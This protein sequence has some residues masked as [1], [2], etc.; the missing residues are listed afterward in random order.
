MAENCKS[1]VCIITMSPT[2]EDERTFKEAKLLTENCKN[3]IVLGPKRVELQDKEQKEGIEII[4]IPF[5]SKSGKQ[6][7]YWFMKFIEKK[8][9]RQIYYMKLLRAARHLNCDYYHAHNPLTLMIMARIC[10]ATTNGKYFGDFNDI[11]NHKLS[12][13]KKRRPAEI[14]DLSYYEQEHVWGTSPNEIDL[15][16]I[17]IIKRHIPDDVK[18]IL[19]AGCGDGKLTNELAVSTD[20]EI[21]GFDFS[22]KA[23]PYVKTP[24]FHGSIDNISVA[25]N[26]YDLVICTE[27]LEHL[28]TVVYKKALQ[29]LS[30]VSK[31]YIIIEL[32]H[33][34]Q[35]AFGIE[36]CSSCGAKFHCNHHYRSYNGRNLKKLFGKSWEMVEVHIVG[37][38][39]F[40]YHPLWLFMRQRLGG[41]WMKSPIAKCTVC[42]T[43][44]FI[45]GYRERNAVS[46]WFND[47]NKKWQA[48]R[49]EVLSQVICL[50]KRRPRGL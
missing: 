30:R 48:K 22:K 46:G 42:G 26:S 3:V 17:N 39:Q 40:Y 32:P 47:R 34:Q 25:D 18:T 4:R 8:F 36:R 5:L 11:I 27:V 1:R 19:D 41:V 38:P 28:P 49:K 23:L 16:R 14:S 29:E 37:G 6:R 31:K 43:P 33:M 7:R 45:T 2:E 44:Q 9:R 35:L 15:A 24:K 13:E 12:V 50:Y 20:F 21:T 10:A